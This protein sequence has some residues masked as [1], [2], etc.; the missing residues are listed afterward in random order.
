MNNKKCIE[1]CQNRIKSSQVFFSTF[2][3]NRKKIKNLTIL[4]LDNLSNTNGIS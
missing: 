2:E 1:Y 4:S 3:N